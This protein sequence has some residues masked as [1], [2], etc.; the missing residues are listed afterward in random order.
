MKKL[1]FIAW[2]GSFASDQS[3]TYYCLTHGAREQN[4]IMSQNANTNLGQL[5]TYE[6][7]GL[8][9]ANKFYESHPKIAKTLLIAGIIDES[10]GGI[11]NVINIKRAYR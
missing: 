7:G 9:L 4:P 6:V 10:Y 5:I 2:I 3:T 11:H 8:A 1:L